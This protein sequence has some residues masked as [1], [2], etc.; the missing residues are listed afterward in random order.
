[1]RKPPLD[2]DVL[3]IGFAGD[4]PPTSGANLLLQNPKRLEKMLRSETYPVQFIFAGKAHPKDNEGKDLIKQIVT[5]GRKTGLSHRFIFSL[6]TTTCILPGTW[7]RGRMC[8]STTPGGP[9]R[10]A[11]PRA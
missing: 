9:M 10:P 7:S 1:M 8:G 6:K 5:F 3:T 11:A 2:P 4:S